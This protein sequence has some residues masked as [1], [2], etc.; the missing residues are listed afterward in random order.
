MTRTMRLPGVRGSLTDELFQALLSPAGSRRIGVPRPNTGD[1]LT[2]DDLQLALYV[3][4]ELHYAHLQNVDERWEWDPSLL[5]FRADLEARLEDALAGVA[6]QGSST[7]NDP[8]SVG[9]YLQQVVASDSRRS[10]SRYLEMEGTTA[11]FVEF[12]I[13]RSAYQ[14]KEAD[15]HSWTIPRLSASPK[16]AL[17]EIQFDEYGAGDAARMHSV[18]FEQTMVGLGLDES[19]G[20][21]VSRLPGITLAT[22]NVISFFGLNRRLRGAAIGHLAM[23]EMTSSIPN[24]RYGNALR[25]LGYGPQATAF[26]DEH[27]LADAAHESIA[28]WDL[29]EGLAKLEPEVEGQIRFGAR[30]LLEVEGRW[31]ES[32]LDAWGAGSSSLLPEG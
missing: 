21:Y 23:F 27:V 31:A 11:Q 14:L 15:P 19:Y 1:V 5:R 12:V 6:G 26:Y 28:V 10:L 22:V 25:R 20:S 16:A 18:L 7:E 9:A 3:C 13:H 4:Y 24:R 2:N 29:A 17:L 30:V 8:G 32:L